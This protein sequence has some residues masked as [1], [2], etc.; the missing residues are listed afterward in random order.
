MSKKLIYGFKVDKNHGTGFLFSLPGLI[1]P[2]K[3]GVA[4]GAGSEYI[5]D[6]SDLTSRG[7]LND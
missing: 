3:N 5:Y 7:K 4:G 6:N 1:K 2:A